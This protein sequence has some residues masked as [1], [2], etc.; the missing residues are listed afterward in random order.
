MYPTH[1]TTQSRNLAG[2][3]GRWSAAHWK[4]ATFGWLAFVLVAFGLGGIVGTRNI[5]SAAGPGESGRMD[6]I[7]E[8][9]FKQPATERVLIQSRSERVGTAAF[10]SA[11]A[12]V[13]ARVSNVAVVRDVR[14]P[15]QPRYAGQISKDARAALVE[16]RIRG[17]KD[18][19][20]DKIDPVLAAVSAAQQAHPGF[21]IGEFGDASAEKGVVTAYDNDLGRAGT[22]SLPITL[23]VLVLTFGSL[24]AAGIPLLLALTAVF[25][26]FG[27]VALSSVVLPVAMQAPA[28]VLLIGLA[29]GVDY[30]MFYLK[31]ARQERAAG[32]SSQAALEIAAA[33]SGRCVLVSGLTVMVA[34]AGMFL[35]GDATF[36]SLAL[37]TILVVAVAVLGSLT[38]L[39][40]VLSRLGDKVDRGRIPFVGRLRRDDGEGRF[41][42]GIVNRVLRRPAL[43]AAAAT[44]VLLALAAPALQ[45]HLAADGPESF[46][47]G[48]DVIQAYDRMQQAFPGS[49]LPA[50]V[51]V[52]ARD[53]RSPA[54]Q[55]AIAQLE[56][57]ALASGRAF[58]PITVD[59]NTNGTIANIIVPIAGNGTDS[60]SNAAFRML[61]NEV[62]PATVGALPDTQAGVTG[63][64]AEWRDQADALR[65]NLPPVVAFVLLFAFVLML[66]AFRSIVVAAKAILL[67]LLSVAAA[68]G[69][70][71]LVFQ[72]GYGSGLLGV[73]STMGISAVVPLLLFVILFGLSMDYH[74]FIL[75]RIRETFDRGKSMDDAVSYG[76][77]STAGV[78]TSAAI[79]MVAVFAVFATLSWPFFKQ[80][81]VGLS[82]AVLIDATIV[83]AVLLPA[84]MKLLGRWNWYLPTW[85]EWLP[86]LEHER[87][88]EPVPQ[89]A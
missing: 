79:V 39:P 42:G 57:R 22:L 88:P 74:V 31:R 24:V 86:R 80:F 73:S 32:R 46:P 58:E 78:V 1:T 3:T 37:A 83:R 18:K 20:V 12:D 54:V 55:Q 56:R 65:S 66:V 87:G 85:L 72:H 51:V 23:I 9:G 68:Y 4:T 43:S 38:V 71:V 29:V 17:A 2:R 7:L 53:V 45:L 62:V 21:T 67:N 89:Q 77:R 8:N 13:V 35:T 60:A 34:M 36:S 44:A 30:S 84:T 19:A 47:K 27:L 15:L 6:Q 41:W 11:I 49:A 70:L 33:T 50:N 82:A 69:V 10:D 76:I 26:T 48:L 59:V 5:E 61:R 81:G 64:T 25:A 28:M 16:F 63:Q 52:E 75:S 40:A 14:S